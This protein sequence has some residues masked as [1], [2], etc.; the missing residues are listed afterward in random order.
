VHACTKWCFVVVDVCLCFPVFHLFPNDDVHTADSV[1]V[2]TGCATFVSP[3]LAGCAP[4]VEVTAAPI[5]SLY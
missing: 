2:G 4:D 3:A 1:T 5:V